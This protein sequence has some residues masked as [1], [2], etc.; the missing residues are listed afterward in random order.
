MHL[1]KRKSFSAPPLLT[2]TEIVSNLLS[3]S[4]FLFPHY[5]LPAIYELRSVWSYLMILKDMSIFF[6]LI[7]ICGPWIDHK[8]KHGLELQYLFQLE[9]VFIFCNTLIIIKWSKIS[10]Q[11]E[12]WTSK[13]NWRL[14]FLW[15]VIWKNICKLF[16]DMVI[17]NGT[18]YLLIFVVSLSLSCS[19]V[20]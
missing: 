16:D 8:L 1:D 3:Q 20:I 11:W 18:W 5:V 6:P 4:L 9:Y 19:E 7:G 14:I 10:F 17:L 2:K 13:Q 12:V 15:I